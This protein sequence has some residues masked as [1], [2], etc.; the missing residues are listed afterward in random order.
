MII[1]KKNILFNNY[2]TYVY[3]LSK[4]WAMAYAHYSHYTLGKLVILQ[5]EIQLTKKKAIYLLHNYFKQIVFINFFYI[6]YIYKYLHIL[7][8]RY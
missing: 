3:F 1:S 7:H 8:Y 2:S 4:F 6:N 5:V